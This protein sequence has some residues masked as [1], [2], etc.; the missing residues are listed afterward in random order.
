MPLS[1]CSAFGGYTK[2]KTQRRLLPHAQE[3]IVPKRCA[4]GT[5]PNPMP[6]PQIG[7][8][9][10]MNPGARHQGRKSRHQDAY[11]PLTS[12]RHVRRH[13]GD[14]V[15]VPV[16]S[17]GSLGSFM[18]APDALGKVG[19]PIVVTWEERLA[20]HASD[21]NEIT[22]TAQ[23]TA[24]A[25]T[26]PPIDEVTKVNPV[27]LQPAQPVRVRLSRTARIPP[28]PTTTGA[29]LARR[30]LDAGSGVQWGIRRQAQYSTAR[31]NTPLAYCR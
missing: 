28:R 19:D 30:G 8:G 15:A 23:R 10:P 27:A 21:R 2:V 31:P 24:L 5:L 11:E 14:T 1:H 26:A 22:C 7:Q 6:E 13:D 17:R 12:Y 9:T 4:K 16:D 29:H 25:T 20:P 18:L 3:R